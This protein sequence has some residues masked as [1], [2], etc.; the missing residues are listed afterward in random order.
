MI[1][2]LFQILCIL[3]L[4][5]CEEARIEV[6]YQPGAIPIQVTITPQG[7]LIVGFSG[8]V[9][10]PTQVYGLDTTFGFNYIRTEYPS[11]ALFVRVDRK[12]NVYDL[13]IEKSFNIVFNDSNPKYKTVSI[14]YES[15]G[16]IVVQLESTTNDSISDFDT[17]T[18]TNNYLCEDINYVKL[19][20]GDN[21]II[22]WPKAN[23]R[24]QPLVP[25]DYYE[26]IVAELE[27]G[28]ILT[29]IDGPECSYK[30]TWWEIRTEHGQTGWIREYIS[31]GYLIR[32]IENQQ[33]S[34]DSTAVVSND[35]PKA[36]T[37]TPQV[38]AV[39][40]AQT[41][42]PTQTLQAVFDE[43]D[44]QLRESLKSHIALNKPK[45]MERD[46]T[47]T[48]ELLLNPSLTEAS[49]ATQ[50]V[51]EGN[52]ITSTADPSLLFSPSGDANS[53]ETSEIKITSIMKAVLSSQDPD[54]FFIKELH[55]TSEQAISSVETTKWTWEVTAKKKGK[56]TLVLVIYRLVNLNGEGYW[57]EVE[58]YKTDI[59][60]EVTVSSWI[61]SLDWKWIAGFIL[62]LIGSVLGILNW[63][64]E[65]E[66][67]EAEKKVSKKHVKKKK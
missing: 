23:L 31:D 42:N 39:T 51:K 46:N 45:E 63:L 44:T 58:T 34:G 4:V 26:N 56:Q 61:N 20:R 62:T 49:L 59:L 52:F 9:T 2:A 12:A 66:K 25:Q 3:S 64:K 8:K 1:K 11:R 32:K 50:L 60:V 16:D 18:P 33:L 54:A 41:P 65:K 47:A 6:G 48:I 10:R 17:S 37:K 67:K 27:E 21:A 13:E 22:A 29:I 35:T 53:I 40:I 15:D 57:R 55:D 38:T 24:S 30:G 7:E 43:I 14:D 19:A 36:I 28:T 5:G